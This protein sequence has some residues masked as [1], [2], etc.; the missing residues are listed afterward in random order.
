MHAL[1]VFF[2]FCCLKTQEK[3]AKQRMLEKAEEIRRSKIAD[4]SSKSS[5]SMQH[6]SGGFGSSSSMSSMSNQSNNSYASPSNYGMDSHMEQ[7]SVPSFSASKSSGRA[8]KLGTNKEAFPAFI[9]QQVKQ[10][11]PASVRQA[12]NQSSQSLGPAGGA[13]QNF[14]KSASSFTFSPNNRL[15]AV[16]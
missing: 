12:D 13:V 1:V 3:E 6:S 15:H 14:E 10:S 7:P 16:V 5:M 2:F 4:K 8:M 11:L 9:E